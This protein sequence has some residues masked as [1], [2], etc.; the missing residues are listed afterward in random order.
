MTTNN[1]WQTLSSTR[2][3]DNAWIAV[4][5]DEVLRPDG[6]PGI[7]GTVHFKHLALGAVVL[8]DERHTWLVGQYRYPLRR[9]SWEIPEG[10]GSA[11]E[12]PLSGIQR[13]LREET[14]I[15]A[16]EWREILRLDL[17]NS[18]TDEQAIVYLATGLS[19][20]EPEP[21]GTE[22]LATR[23]IPFDDALGMA[24]RGEIT[25]AISVAA[26]LRVKLLLDQ[27]DV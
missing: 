13:E 17:S 10:G 11:V 15:S 4:S 25:D 24:M 22:S 7:Y 9:Y 23:R 19:F 18:V 2:I 8:D 21:D 1:P 20:G 14:G 12:S 3:Y 16:R 26:L 5:H 6:Q 27:G